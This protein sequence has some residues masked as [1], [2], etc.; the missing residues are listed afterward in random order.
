TDLE[1]GFEGVYPAQVQSEGTLTLN[2]RKL[3]EIIR[4][5]PNDNIKEVSNEV[6]NLSG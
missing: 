2:S 1:T 6:Y 3:F 4:D 5:F